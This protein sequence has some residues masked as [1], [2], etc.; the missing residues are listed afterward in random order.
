MILVDLSQFMITAV[1]ANSN[2]AEI[3]E[4]F[5]R[6][7]VLNNLRAQR[8]KF[9]KEY[10]ELVLAID[11]RDTWRKKTY[12]YYKANRKKSRASSDIDWSEVYRI[13]DVLISELRNTFPYKVVKV[14]NTEGDDI[15]ATICMAHAD[16]KTI[17]LSSD[18]DFKQLQVYPNVKQWDPFRTKWIKEE[19]PAKYLREHIIRGDAGDG[20]PNFLSPDNVFVTQGIR[21]KSIMAPKLAEWLSVSED[22]FYNNLSTDQQANY[23]RNKM[24]IDFTQ[25]PDA[26]Q[27]SILEEYH[28]PVEGHRSKI[29]TY[30]IKHRMKMLME[31]LQDF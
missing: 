19:D 16:E 10:G 18:K 27:E 28:K 31:C 26:I 1:I 13:I 7:L 5:V 14:P 3:S 11:S 21:Q 17:I 29:M 23:M 25:I 12:E 15:I 8:K 4:D 9:N 30:F 20:I 6:H 24:L 22:E 2:Q